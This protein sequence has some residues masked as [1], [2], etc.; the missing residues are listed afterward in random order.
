MI[1]GDTPGRANSWAE[2][3]II[4]VSNKE[5]EKKEKDEN[6]RTKKNGLIEQL[7]KQCTRSKK[8]NIIITEVG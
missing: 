3:K 2:M 1:R 6:M 7:Q 8:K 5:C 4:Y